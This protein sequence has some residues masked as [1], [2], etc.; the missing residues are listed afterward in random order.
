MHTRF[1][2]KK[3][4]NLN[5]REMKVENVLPEH[6]AAYYPNFIALLERYYEFQDQNSSTELLNHLFATRDVT[7]TDITL[8]SYIEDELLL[9]DAYF[10][11]LRKENNAAELRAAANFSN[12]LFRSKGTKFAI[13]WFFRSFYN[14]DVEVLY[15]KENI[16]KVSDTDSKIGPESLRFLTDDKLY[17]TFALLVRVGVSISEWKDVFKLFT[18]PAGMYLGSEVSITDDILAALQALEVTNSFNNVPSRLSTEY[19]FQTLVTSQ[20]E[21]REWTFTVQATET[22]YDK[23]ALYWYGEH[24]TTTD[25]D[26]GINSYDQTSGLPDINNPQYFELNG[27]GGTA[28]GSF[29]LNTILDSYGDPAEQTSE[30]FTIYVTDRAGRIVLSQVC[31]LEDRLPGWVLRINGTVS[32]STI[33]VLEGSDIEFVMSAN[34]L[35]NL[36]NNGEATLRWYFT[37]GTAVDADFEGT[38]PLLGNAQEFNVT[39]GSGS[40]TVKSVLDGATD[41]GDETATFTIINEYGYV[42][43]TQEIQILNVIP[44]IGATSPDIIEGQDLVVTVDITSSQGSIPSSINEELTWTILNSDSRFPSST[45]TANYTGSTLLINIPTTASN[46]FEPIVQNTVEISGLGVTGSSTFSISNLDPEYELIVDKPI[47]PG[48]D[49]VT[50][51]IGG[52]NVDPSVPVYF[53]ID[54]IGVD[55]NDFAAVASEPFPDYYPQDANRRVVTTSTTQLRYSTDP[56]RTNNE[57]YQVGI[58]DIPSGGGANNILATL[59][60]NIQGST[61]AITGITP[62]STN[63]NEGSIFEMVISGTDDTYKYWFVGDIVTDDFSLVR[64]DQNDG[65][66]LVTAEFGTSTDKKDITLTSGSANIRVTVSEDVLREGMENFQLVIGENSTGAEIAISPVYTI[67]DTS[68]ATY[69]ITTVDA[70]DEI[71]TSIAEGNDLNVNIAV[72]AGQPVEDLEI[73]ITGTGASTFFSSTVQNTNSIPGGIASVTFPNNSADAI[74]DGPRTITITASVEGTEVASGSITLTDA[75]EVWNFELATTEPVSLGQSI[76]WSTDVYNLS[77]FRRVEARFTDM[78]LVNLCTIPSNGSSDYIYTY[79]NTPGTFQ[80][81]GVENDMYVWADFV[82][83]DHFGYPN[84]PFEEISYGSN[85]PPGTILHG[86]N[87]VLIGKVTNATIPSTSTQSSGERYTLLLDRTMADPVDVPTTA[88]TLAKTYYFGTE[89][90]FAIYP[91][92]KQFVVTQ[93]GNESSFNNITVNSVNDP[94]LFSDEQNF[95]WSLYKPLEL[96]LTNPGFALTYDSTELATDQVTVAYP[97]V[98]VQLDGTNWNLSNTFY[99]GF[100]KAQISITFQ[101]SDGKV[102]FSP[103]PSGYDSSTAFKDGDSWLTNNNGNP[104]EQTWL[105]AGGNA[106]DYMIRYREDLMSDY[107][108]DV[109]TPTGTSNNGYYRLDV[110]RTWTQEDTTRNGV[111]SFSRGVLEIAEY[112]SGSPGTVIATVRLELLANY[113]P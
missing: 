35:E 12:I 90:T 3:R 19:A 16:F 84:G 113:E 62:A 101:A 56:A 45:G 59:D 75:G 5:L 76:I 24:G 55:A 67:L 82:N 49:I 112:T 4:R 34:D 66:G 30:T 11:G 36:P 23:D 18:H 97:P 48:N 32:G 68:A 109:I 103:L 17:Q 79:K 95:S 87:A 15:P 106:S 20:E 65:L 78:V 52:N 108:D 94:S 51:T 93:T 39:A 64:K 69:E 8:L 70:Q 61:P 92:F 58:N 89:E 13:E 46:T 100:S 47:A 96:T 110:S 105:G 42:L 71:I 22:P 53:Y 6:F 54:P 77:D 40:F 50:F 1:I 60:L 21:G 7:E 38:M 91:P 104:W 28:Q 111:A 99:S 81:L 27:S 98:T 44:I 33:D 74:I 29:N 72:S 80:D 9:G 85:P 31:T 10:D 102:V 14:E 2:D 88:D 41:S 37:P 86:T 83:E 73:E 25:A 57:L 43:K 26:F 63:I 107:T